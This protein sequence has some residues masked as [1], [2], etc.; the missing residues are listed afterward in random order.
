MREMRK[1]RIKKPKVVILQ[2]IAEKTK[3]SKV[4]H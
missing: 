2:N 1:E 3:S 4:R